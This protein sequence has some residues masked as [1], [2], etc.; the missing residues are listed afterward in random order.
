MMYIT[1]QKQTYRYRE[2]VTSEEWEKGRNK[3]GV[4]V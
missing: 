4:G 1:K 3:I 2:Q